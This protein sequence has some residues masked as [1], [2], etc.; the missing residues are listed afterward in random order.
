VAI[1]SQNAKNYKMLNPIEADRKESTAEHT[2]HAEKQLLSFEKLMRHLPQK[3][4]ILSFPR[5]RESSVNLDV[6]WTPACAGVTDGMFHYLIK[7]Q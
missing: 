2:K 7:H 4:A 5:K 6:K 1:S 3:P